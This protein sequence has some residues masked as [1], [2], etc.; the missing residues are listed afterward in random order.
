MKYNN[1]KIYWSMS[2]M[3]IDV[4]KILLNQYIKKNQTHHHV[5][6]MLGL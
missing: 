5:K 2:L 6:F 3:N 4:N 1:E